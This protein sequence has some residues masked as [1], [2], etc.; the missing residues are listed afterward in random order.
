MQF[1][2]FFVTISH[3]AETSVIVLSLS[4]DKFKN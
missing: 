2:R 4:A 3:M 1:F